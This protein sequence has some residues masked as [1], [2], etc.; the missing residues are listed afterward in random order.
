MKV[1]IAE[2]L[3][4]LSILSIKMIKIKEPERL[5]E[6]IK[7]YNILSKDLE[8]Y[9]DKYEFYYK[10]LAKINKSIWEKLDLFREATSGATKSKL[11][12]EVTNENDDRYR[13]KKKINDICDSL[14]KEQK[15]YKLKSAFYLPH[16]G[17]GD[18]ICANGFIRYLSTQYD[19]VTVVCKR[20]YEKNMRL[21]FNDDKSIDFYLVDYDAE[22]SPAY[23]GLQK[24]NEMASTNDMYTVG[25]HLCQKL[26]HGFEDLPFNF[27]D[28]LKV[29]RSIFWEYH[30]NAPLT[31][32]DDLYYSHLDGQKYIFIHTLTSRGPTFTIGEA[33][34]EFGFDRHETLV[35]DPCTNVYQEGDKYYNLAKKL[36]YHPVYQYKTVIEKASKIVISDSSFFCLTITLPTE[37]RN[38][39]LKPR[40]RDNYKLVNIN[41][42]NN[43]IFW[44]Q[45][46]EKAR[47]EDKLKI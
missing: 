11:C 26:S 40:T 23:G 35:I 6:V 46:K 17:L 15:G 22:I 1:S 41:K 5:R 47:V 37:V 45:L 10:I 9:K 12:M 36:I 33:E 30:H 38:I 24:F 44:P 8:E 7:E 25:Y 19:K 2:A 43:F 3:D 29:D 16:L 27:Y 4:K 14:I 21:M 39:Y 34:K 32:E 42:V 13:V 28:D 20:H 18:C 31:R